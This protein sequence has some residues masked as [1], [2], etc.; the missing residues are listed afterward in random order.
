MVWYFSTSDR[1]NLIVS[2]SRQQHHHAPT[3]HDNYDY[4]NSKSHIDHYSPNFLVSITVGNSGRFENSGTRLAIHSIPSTRPL[5]GMEMEISQQVPRG[6]DPF[7][8]KWSGWTM[9][10]TSGRYLHPGCFPL[11]PLTVLFLWLN[12]PTQ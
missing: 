10:W 2:T 6:M 5:R 1:C 4:T 3:P 9:E 7:G 11:S 12:P 8:G